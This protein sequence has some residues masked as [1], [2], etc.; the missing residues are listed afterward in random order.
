MLVNSDV[1]RRHPGEGDTSLSLKKKALPMWRVERM[2]I[3]GREMAEC[4]RVS[5]H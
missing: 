3:F 1:Q 4:L 2:C 5:G